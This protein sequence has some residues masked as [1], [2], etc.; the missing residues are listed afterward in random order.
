M[1]TVMTGPGMIA[2]ENP[3]PKELAKINIKGH[4]WFS[5]IY[6]EYNNDGKELQGEIG[7]L[8]RSGDVN[9]GKKSFRYLG[10][11]SHERRWP[12]RSRIGSFLR[13]GAGRSSFFLAQVITTGISSPLGERMKSRSTSHK[14]GNAG[15]RKAAVRGQPSEGISTLTPALSR[16][17][18][19]GSML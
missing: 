5:S 14:L 15:C 10:F 16:Q 1:V 9:R 8:D 6:R 17:R 4:I 11:L 19:R 7:L 12:G 13:L 3:T 18:E 2:P